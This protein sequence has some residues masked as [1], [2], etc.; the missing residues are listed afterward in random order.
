MISAYELSGLQTFSLAQLG[1][2]ESWQEPCGFNL[3]NE[4]V[5]GSIHHEGWHKEGVFRNLLSKTIILATVPEF[6]QEWNPLEALFDWEIGPLVWL[7][8]DTG[9]YTCVCVYACVF[10]CVCGVIE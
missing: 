2:Q 5:M 8:P 3:G 9:W 10:V 4:M 1:I 7:I 6:A